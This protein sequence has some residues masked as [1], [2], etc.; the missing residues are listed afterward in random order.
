MTREQALELACLA[1]DAAIHNQ[2]SVDGL[3][4]ELRKAKRI[5]KALIKE[6]ASG[7]R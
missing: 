5:I 2:G 1:L 4:I 6:L 3:H 7:E